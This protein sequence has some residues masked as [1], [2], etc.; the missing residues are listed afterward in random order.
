MWEAPAFAAYL[1]LDSQWFLLG[2]GRVLTVVFVVLL[3]GED[4]AARRRPRL[5]P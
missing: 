5:P 4:A 3:G 1:P 2:V